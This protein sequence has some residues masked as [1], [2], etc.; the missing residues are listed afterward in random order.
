M[1]ADLDSNSGGYEIDVVVYSQH[2][3][4]HLHSN[5]YHAEKTRR[6]LPKYSSLSNKIDFYYYPF[7]LLL[8]IAAVIIRQPERLQPRI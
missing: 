3:D 6:H 5:A 7:L 1:N 2:N 4:T 8:H